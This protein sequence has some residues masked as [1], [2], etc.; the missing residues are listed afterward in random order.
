MTQ[1]QAHEQGG[2][3]P[4]SKASQAVESIHLGYLSCP[5]APD[6]GYTGA[7][8]VT[9]FYTRPLHFAYVGSVRPNRM[10][11]ILYGKTL[12]EG[13]KVEVIAKKLL[14]EHLAV[15]P[16]VLFVEEEEL[17]AVRRFTDFP[18]AWLY[19]GEESPSA[20]S[21][22][23]YD[24]GENGQDRDKVG[25]IMMKLEQSV[26]PLDPFKRMKEALREAEKA[27]HSSE[28]R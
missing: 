19:E 18:V 11:R 3:H 27:T 12:N 24:T 6:K 8:F 10:Q 16:S 23:Q 28:E 5:R 25:K 15:I 17:L 1:T 13:V 22:I 7:L 4:E 9:D 21:R 14:I 20:L 26:M 2:T